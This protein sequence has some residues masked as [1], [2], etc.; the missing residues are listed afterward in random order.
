ML[1]GNVGTIARLVERCRSGDRKGESAR[2]VL[3]ALSVSQHVGI[4][5]WGSKRLAKWG[6]MHGTKKA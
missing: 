6:D 5:V 1:K 3:Q 4:T 2:Q